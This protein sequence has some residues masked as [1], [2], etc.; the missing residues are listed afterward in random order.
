MLTTIPTDLI[1]CGELDDKLKIKREI[2]YDDKIQDENP[3]VK[4]DKMDRYICPHCAKGIA[5][6]NCSDLPL[7][8]FKGLELSSHAN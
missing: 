6:I 5:R 1:V 2:Y 3:V 4:R 8:R 7:T